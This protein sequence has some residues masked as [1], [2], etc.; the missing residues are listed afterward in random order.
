MFEI[1]ELTFHFPMT[2][3]IYRTIP[4][5]LVTY[6]GLWAPNKMT[7]TVPWTKVAM[8]KAQSRSNPAGNERVSAA[9]ESLRQRLE[10]LR[11][12]CHY[13]DALQVKGCSHG[14]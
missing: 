12:I 13:T 11:T 6:N 8:Q 1:G 7:G 4:T 10:N 9:R 2:A 5:I 3:T 14:K